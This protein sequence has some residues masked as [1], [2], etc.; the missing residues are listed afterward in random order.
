MAKKTIA[1]EDPMLR[2]LRDIKRLLVLQ[3]ISSGVQGVHV[4]AALQVD[5]GTVSRMVPARG[6]RKG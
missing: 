2:E 4:A 3:L 6:L 5:P 1:P